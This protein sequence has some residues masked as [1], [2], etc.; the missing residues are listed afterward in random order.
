MD[1]DTSRRPL[2]AILILAAVGHVAA[3]AW[4]AALPGAQPS[5]PVTLNRQRTN[6]RSGP[7]SGQVVFDNHAAPVWPLP[8]GNYQ[9]YFLC[10]DGYTILAGPIALSITP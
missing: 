9:A 3:G 2:A 6:G 8:E 7:T 1:R 5:S 4:T 10:C